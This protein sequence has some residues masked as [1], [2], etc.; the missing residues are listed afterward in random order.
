MGV[1]EEQRNEI[2]KSKSLVLN[3][4]SLQSKSLPRKKLN[5]QHKI[6]FQVLKASQVDQAQI[7]K[8]E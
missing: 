6:S 8:D 3:V 5:L 1:F 7:L 2:I 4:F